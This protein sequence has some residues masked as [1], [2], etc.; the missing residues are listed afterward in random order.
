MIFDRF[1]HR[2]KLSSR[3]WF[4][5]PNEKESTKEAPKQSCFNQLIDADKDP[6]EFKL[7]EGSTFMF[8]KKIKRFL[9]KDKITRIELEGPAFELLKNRIDWANLKGNILH[10]DLSKLLLLEGPLGRKS[11]LTRYFFNKDLEYLRYGNTEKKH[12]LSLTKIYATRY[13][14]ARIEENITYL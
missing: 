12:A 9:K 2:L 10:N 5:Q 4:K 3:D 1:P 8:A 14:E 6:R 13:E 7:Q 11:I